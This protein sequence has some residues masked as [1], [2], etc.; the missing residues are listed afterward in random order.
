MNEKPI[1]AVGAVNDWVSQ[2]MTTR[3]FK[4][5]D[6]VQKVSGYRYPGVVVAVFQTTAGAVRYVVE[7]TVPECAGM[8]H[9]YNGSQLEAI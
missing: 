3:V 6:K 8:L 4:Q 9:I 2:H 5:G 1:F 7:S